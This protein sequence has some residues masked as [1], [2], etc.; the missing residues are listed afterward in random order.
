MSRMQRTTKKLFA[1]SLICLMIFVTVPGVK[2]A[3][4]A[5]ASAQDEVKVEFFYESERLV[6]KKGDV[7]F[8]YYTTDKVGSKVPGINKW[9]KVPEEGFDCSGITSAKT[10]CFANSTTPVS[11][12]IVKVDIPAKPKIIK[13]AYNAAKDEWTV[14]ANVDITGRCVLNGAIYG[15]TD[16]GEIEILKAYTEDLTLNGGY[17]FALLY[18]LDAHGELASMD[19]ADSLILDRQ[20][21]DEYYKFGPNASRRSNEKILKIS[22]KS[23]GPSVTVDYN[24]HYISV[25]ANVSA[26]YTDNESQIADYEKGKKPE[27]SKIGNTTVYFYGED[28]TVYNFRTDGNGK[29]AESLD[30][31]VPIGKTSSFSGCFNMTGGYQKDAL[32]EVYPDG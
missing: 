25:P 16:E 22:R 4:V 17:A 23:N 24:N 11:S 18:P 13:L 8:L 26:V 7:Q 10:I 1:I 9:K 20:Y 31:I 21:P 6:V 3:M 28:S 2:R 29:K 27:A 12:E 14:R 19:S 5:K 32:L 30:T 15:S